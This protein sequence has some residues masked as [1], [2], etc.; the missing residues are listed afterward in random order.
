MY[1]TTSDYANNEMSLLKALKRQQKGSKYRY[2]DVQAK[3]KD[4]TTTVLIIDY[5]YASNERGGWNMGVTTLWLDSQGLLQ[6]SLLSNH[7]SLVGAWVEH[8]KNI[9]NYRIMLIKK[10]LVEKALSPNFGPPA[11][12]N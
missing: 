3:A 9:K 10:E 8:I 5:N 1:L 7:S 11:A 12:K 4:Q 6:D 2:K